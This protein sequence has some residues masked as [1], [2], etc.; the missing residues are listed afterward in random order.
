MPLSESSRLSRVTAINLP[1]AVLGNWQ[2]ILPS[3]ENQDLLGELDVK[4]APKKNVW[5]LK[6]EGKFLN[7]DILSFLI[8]GF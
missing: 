7:G 3:C 4:C 2:G 8:V 6:A 5:V 1:A